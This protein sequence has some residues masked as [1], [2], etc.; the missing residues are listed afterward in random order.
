MRIVVHGESVSAVERLRMAL[1]GVAMRGHDV[2]WVG[3]GTPMAQGVRELGESAVRGLECDVVVGAA[4]PRRVSDLGRRARAHAMVFHLTAMQLRDWSVW[5]RW[6][7]E[8]MY[9]L[10]LSE[11]IEAGALRDLVGERMPLERFALWPDKPPAMAPD[12]THPDTEVLERALERALARS[13]GVA[14]RSAAFVDR[15]GTL[16]VERGYLSDP[17]GVELLPD[18]AAALRLL[19]SAGHPV[20]V[21]SNQSGVGRGKFLATQVHEVMAALRRLLR[22]EGVEIDAIRFCPHAP[23]EGCVCR[24]PGT[25][26]FE[27]VAGDLQLALRASMM[28]G[29]KRLD[30]AAGHAMEGTGVLVRT[31]YGRQ[32]ESSI[33]DGRFPP[34][35]AVFDTLLAAAEWFTSR[36]EGRTAL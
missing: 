31:G 11:E 5:E 36:E 1:A 35:D 21:I 18:V 29:D 10:S 14:L 6:G 23:D 20:V 30:A 13:R 9:A 27:Q 7:W 8:S 19:R 3:P 12:T 15:D 2:I 25:Q 22:A 33:G 26:L 17:A 32:E 24:K 34:P 4:L 28:V 16:V